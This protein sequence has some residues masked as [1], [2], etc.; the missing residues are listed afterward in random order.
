MILSVSLSLSCSDGWAVRPDV[1]QGIEEAAAGGMSI[2]LYSP[3]LE[4][5]DKHYLSLKPDNNNR[6][7]W[8]REFWQQKFECYLPGTQGERQYPTPC[9]GELGTTGS[10]R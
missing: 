8:F 4:D 6:N 5:F 7:P 9:T 10:P 1:V 2:K 3:P